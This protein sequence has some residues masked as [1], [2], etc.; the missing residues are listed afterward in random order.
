MEDQS[1]TV[2]GDTF[3]SGAKTPN[4]T[5]ISFPCGGRVGID[6]SCEEDRSIQMGGPLMKSSRRLTKGKVV[7]CGETRYVSTQEAGLK[8]TTSRRFP[9]L[10]PVTSTRTSISSLLTAVYTAR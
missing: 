10:R 9:W 5:G 7:S 1:L 6:S 3:S 8:A 4:V 2:A